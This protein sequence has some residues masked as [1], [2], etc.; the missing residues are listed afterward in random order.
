MT[1]PYGVSEI[2]DG[3]I[4]VVVDILQCSVLELRRESIPFLIYPKPKFNAWLPN[5]PSW[6]FSFENLQYH[7]L[8]SH[9]FNLK[10]LP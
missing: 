5:H 8:E 4:E 10:L 9:L 2:A 7:L 1:H 3:S 6:F